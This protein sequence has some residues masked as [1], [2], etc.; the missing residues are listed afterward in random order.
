[1]DTSKLMIS[2]SILGDKS[3]A[4]KVARESSKIMEEFRTG[5]RPAG[6]AAHPGEAVV[7]DA[8]I[9]IRTYRLV[10]D[11][12]PEA[13]TPLEAFPPGVADIGVVPLDEAIQRRRLGLTRLEEGTVG[14]RHGSLRS[15]G[16]DGCRETPTRRPSSSPFALASGREPVIVVG[17]CSPPACYVL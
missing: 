4:D 14:N 5:S 2:I 9:E 12:S 10:G 8:A 6:T 15:R 1:M 7:E 13:V 3:K 16:V 11:S 17:G